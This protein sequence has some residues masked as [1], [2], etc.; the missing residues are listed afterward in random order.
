M[1]EKLSKTSNL[2]LRMFGRD[3]NKSAGSHWSTIL[4]STRS[5]RIINSLLIPV[6]SRLIL[7]A[8]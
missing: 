8:T 5:R 2:P 7:Y 6:S 3:L 4:G 1:W